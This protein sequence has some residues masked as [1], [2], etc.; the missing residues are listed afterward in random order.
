MDL[1]ARMEQNMS[2]QLTPSQKMSLEILQLN[3][4]NLELRISEELEKNPLL[5]VV[6]KGDETPDTAELEENG[7]LK[8]NE[9][10]EI[11]G[12]HRESIEEYFEPYF[13][14]DSYVASSNSLNTDE[15][16]DPLVNLESS[17]R[18]F[19]NF[20]WEQL[21]YL[22]PSP[23]LR[24]YIE[25]LVSHLDERGYLTLALEDVANSEVNTELNS[26]SKWKDALQFVQYKLDPPGLGASSLKECLIIQIKRIGDD[27]EFELS[28]IEN[29]FEYLLQ[30]KLN[31]IA[32]ETQ[33]GIEKIVEVIDFMRTLS[34]RPAAPFNE[35]PAALLRPD[36]IVKYDRPDALNKKGRFSI[37][38]S[39]KGIP[40]L[41]VI[42]G[43]KYQK[44]KLSKKEKL[45]I[46]EQVNS[47]KSLVEAIRRRNETLFLV[48]QSICQ[49]QKAF[50][51]EGKSGLKSLL[52]Q[53]IANELDM[54]AATITRTVKDKVIQTDY[55][56][57]PLK[58]FFSMKKVK[59]G[60]GEV[61]ERDQILKALQE[62]VE[63]EDKK[64]PLSD[65]LISKKLKEKNFKVATRTVS[66]YRD[67]LEIPS[68]SKRKKF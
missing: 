29:H 61:N 49:N 15:E 53:E 18:N 2:M 33:V 62:I 26:M 56:I 63:T 46:M 38:L 1:N 67:M 35:Q 10:N 27:F 58:Y 13:N 3:I 32:Q 11:E 48:I 21:E 55:G 40:E 14:E 31:L 50:F 57:F 16:N 59:M 65:A 7:G 28:I 12:E 19:E 9:E 20:I 25:V 52:M 54:S 42:P 41:V 34:F 6:E 37:L 30:N 17:E 47:G 43:T 4:Q 60:G 44:E 39:N 36:A 24:P 66:K 51:E 8:K 22:N 68:S 23:E 45:Y 64:K 5:E